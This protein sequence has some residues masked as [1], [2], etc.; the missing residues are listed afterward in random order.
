MIYVSQWRQEQ[1]SPEGCFKGYGLD[2]QTRTQESALDLLVASELAHGGKVTGL[3][4]TKIVVV[5]EF[6]TKFDTTVFEGSADEMTILYRVAK[7]L[8]NGL[9]PYGVP[10]PTVELIAV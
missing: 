5:T 6:R 8:P 9:V 3:T 1:G 7:S 10:E 2:P 4:P